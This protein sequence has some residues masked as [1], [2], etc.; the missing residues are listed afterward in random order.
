LCECKNNVDLSAN[1]RQ[2][3]FNM[4]SQ[5]RSLNNEIWNGS[6]HPRSESGTD[7]TEGPVGPK[8]WPL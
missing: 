4:N 5:T 2:N 3:S 7:S 1:S 8:L 6:D